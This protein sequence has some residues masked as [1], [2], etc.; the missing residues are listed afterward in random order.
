M[1][2]AGF[3]G[4]LLQ[5]TLLTCNFELGIAADL[6]VPTSLSGTSAAGNAWSI[7]AQNSSLCDAGSK[8]WTGTVKVGDGKALF[9]CM[10]FVHGMR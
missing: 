5:I 10:H 7:K 9:F 2:A 8:Q 3:F 1:R 4:I 6:P